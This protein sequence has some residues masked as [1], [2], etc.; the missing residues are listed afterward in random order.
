LF[1]ILAVVAV[2]RQVAAK[3]MLSVMAK[4]SSRIQPQ[5]LKAAG[6]VR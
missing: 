4:A 3:P 5:R 1:E 2:S 6:R